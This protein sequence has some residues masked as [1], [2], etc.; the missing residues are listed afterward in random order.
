MSSP[1][2]VEIEQ[3]RLLRN[4]P[5]LLEEVQ[6]SDL[7][8]F[9]LQAALRQRYP[10]ELVIA[11]LQL[12]DA[13]SRAR[14][15]FSRAAEMWLDGTGVEQST[16]E[17][18]ARHKMQRFADCGEVW[19]LFTHVP[20]LIADC[21][22]LLAPNRAGLVLTVYAIRASAIAFD[23]LLRDTLSD[24]GGVF[25]T[26][27]LAIRAQSGPMVPTSLFVRWTSAP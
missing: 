26:G 11:A 6:S 22:K 5:E 21:A 7:N 23:Q 2:V 24:R 20:G 3:L 13:R 8:D 10:R 27:E 25:D 4:T 18:V 9:Q 17:L 12:G 16:S 14:S 19:D 15:K 1:Q